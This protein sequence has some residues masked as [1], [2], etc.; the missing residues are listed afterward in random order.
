MVNNSASVPPSEGPTPRRPLG[1]MTELYTD[2]KTDLRDISKFSRAIILRAAR[3]TKTWAHRNLLERALLAFAAFAG[4]LA[5]TCLYRGLTRDAAA[6]GLTSGLLSLLALAILQLGLNL[7][8]AVSRVREANTYHPGKPV[9]LLIQV[10]PGT[11]TLDQ[12]QHDALYLARK[13]EDYRGYRKILGCGEV[14]DR[15]AD[16]ALA[17][18]ARAIESFGVRAQA[19]GSEVVS[20]RSRKEAR[21]LYSSIR[22][23]SHATDLDAMVVSIREFTRPRQLGWLARRRSAAS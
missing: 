21:V 11:R 18:F 15:H 12:L 8:H 13:L 23:P 1:R 4:T 10:N 9:T 22:C 16:K 3:D 20:R 19:L 6:L 7:R 14:N 17:E 2:L 5:A